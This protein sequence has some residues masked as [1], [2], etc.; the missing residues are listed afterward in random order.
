MSEE[1]KMGGGET[2]VCRGCGID[3]P[4]SGY[5]VFGGKYLDKLCRQCRNK[6]SLHNKK[7]REAR[8]GATKTM[9][10]KSNELRDPSTCHHLNKVCGE[11]LVSQRFEGFYET[12]EQARAGQEWQVCRDCGTAKLIQV[13]APTAEDASFERIVAHTRESRAVAGAREREMEYAAYAPST[14][15]SNGHVPSVAVLEGHEPHASLRPD[16]AVDD[17][18]VEDVLLE[19][20][21]GG[22]GEDDGEGDATVDDTGVPEPLMSQVATAH[23]YYDESMAV[24]QTAHPELVEAKR[25][26]RES[27]TDRAFLR[28][29]V[30]A[31][32]VK[33]ERL[34]AKDLWRSLQK[35][36][37]YHYSRWLKL[38]EEVSELSDRY[39]L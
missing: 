5:Y 27:E 24:S 4:N 9:N 17:D 20:G 14:S 8:K 2:K 3:K 13:Y 25:A 19:A 31:L 38:S 28:V 10:D 1:A 23:I 33:I 37:E 7:Q 26:L 39:G 18:D 12:H 32:E 35:Q 34:E 11:P 6:L 16:L 36:A 30:A 22:D 15:T 21:F 29:Q